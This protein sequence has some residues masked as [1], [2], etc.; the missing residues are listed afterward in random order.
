MTLFDSASTCHS[1][2]FGSACSLDLPASS[3]R[4]ITEL[5][6]DPV[7]AHSAKF[8]LEAMRGLPRTMVGRESFSWFNHGFWYQPELPQNLA[9]CTD[10]A[11][12]YVK[13][14][15]KDDSFWSII[16]QENKRLLGDLPHN[17][18]SDLISG[19]QAQ[20]IYMIMFALD[21]S[22]MDEIPEIRLNMLMTFEVRLI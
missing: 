9:K 22:S 1:P 8:V 10:F 5:R 15:S 21:H 19:M 3:P 14:Q 7:A 4:L 2:T 6:S 17:S 11:V 13:R 12:T 16:S 18:L 20:I